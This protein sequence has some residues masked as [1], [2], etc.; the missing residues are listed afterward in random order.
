MIPGSKTTKILATIVTI[1]LLLVGGFYSIRPAKAI[2]VE[3]ILGNAWDTTQYLLSKAG[4]IAFQ[5]IGRKVLNQLAYD[6]ATSI[7]SGGKG[8]QPLFVTKDWSAYLTDMGDKAAGDFIESFANS[9]ATDYKSKGGETDAYNEYLECYD[10]CWENDDHSTIEKCI[11]SCD[12][13]FDKSI[14][15]LGDNRK[16]PML[17][18]TQSPLGKIN[19]CNP[20]TP[21]ASV[22]IGLGLTS[23]TT[24]W[25]P[26]CKFSKMAKNWTDFGKKLADMKNPDYM[27]TLITVFDDPYS[28]DLGAALI[29]NTN[30][31]AAEDKNVADTRSQLEAGKGWLDTRDF[32]GNL[33]GT[34]LNSEEEKKRT[35][36]E[37]W[38]NLD[39]VTGDI[40]VDAA[41]IFLNRLALV[42]W[43]NLMGELGS[44]QEN[45]SLGYWSGRPTGRSGLQNRINSIK[46]PFYTS[47]NMTNLLSDL[48]IC[49]ESGLQSSTSCVITNAFSD[50]VTSKMTLIEAVQSGRVPGD[51]PFGFDNKG[52][53]SLEYQQGYPYRSLLILRKYRIIPVGWELAAQKIQ[54]EYSKSPLGNDF[55]S[56]P[57]GI[58]L[59]DLIACYNSS[60][61]YTGYY[62]AWC[63][64]LVDPHWVLELPDT[65]CAAKGYGP[66]LIRE[67]ESTDSRIKYCSTDKGKTKAKIDFGPSSGKGLGVVRCDTN[68][69]CCKT[70]EKVG[71]CD[72]T[73]DYTETQTILSRSKDYC[74]DEQSCI[75]EG[76]DGKCQFYGYCAKERRKWV[77]S[78]DGSDESCNPIYNTCRAFTGG[79]TAKKKVN[80]LENTLDFSGCNINNAGCKQYAKGMAAYNVNNDV[81]TWDPADLIH[82]DSDAQECRAD[83]EGCHEFVRVMTGG[84]ANL[85]GDGGFENNDA[86]HWTSAGRLSDVEKIDGDYSLYI[87]DMTGINSKNMTLLPKGFVFER[88][89]KYAISADVYVLNGK[90]ELGFGNSADPNSWQKYYSDNNNKW[91]SFSIEFTNDFTINADTFYLRG[92]DLSSSFYVDNLKIEL[93]GISPYANYGERGLVYEK[94]LPKYLEAYCY[95]D[96]AKGDYGLK[97][98][99]ASKCFDYVRKCNQDEVGCRMFTDT[100][101]RENV[102]AV[103]NLKDYCAKECV[104]FNV[105]VQRENNYYSTRDEYFVPKTAE[106]CP[107]SANG[108][109]LF[110]N[111]DKQGQGG[112]ANEYYTHLRSCVKPDQPDA[113]CSEFYTWEGSNESGYQLV[114]FTLQ[115]N[116]GSLLGEPETT[117]NDYLECNEYVFKMAANNPYYNSDC[118]QFYTRDGQI[119]YHLYNATIACSEQCTP[120]RLAENNLDVNI[121]NPT[122]CT[123][124]NGHW[125]T[126]NSVCITCLGNGTWSDEQQGCIYQGLTD[127]SSKC[128]ASQVGCSEYV[129]NFG[130]NERVIFNS[131]F[132]KI[133]DGWNFGQLSN[134]STAVGGHS[135]HANRGMATKN[136]SKLIKK[137]KRYVLRFL[138]KTDV[139][140]TQNGG[141]PADFLVHVDLRQGTSYLQHFL[142]DNNGTPQNQATI[143]LTDKWQQYEV[144]INDIDHEIADDEDLQIYGNS[145]GR[146]YIDNIK[147]VEVSDQYFLIKNSWSWSAA[148]NEDNDGKSYPLFALG[149]K[150]Y[151]DVDNNYHYL[152]SFSQICQDSAAGCELMIDTQ[153]SN[154]YRETKSASGITVPADEMVYLVYDKDK[155]CGANQQGCAR[156]GRYSNVFNKYLDTYLLNEPD[157]YGTTLCSADAVGCEAWTD[158]QGSAVYFKDPGDR[159]C[160]YRTP[161]AGGAEAW[162]WQYVKRCGGVAIGNICLANSDCV[163]GERCVLDE[164]DVKCNEGKVNENN[165]VPNDSSIPKTLGYGAPVYQPNTVVG[166]CPAVQSSCTE[167]IDPDSRANGN[168]V[169]DPSMVSGGLQSAWIST[170]NGFEQKIKVRTNT[171][172]LVGYIVNSPLGPMTVSY[173]PG[174]AGSYGIY[175]LNSSNNLVRLE[176]VNKKPLH[177]VIVNNTSEEIYLYNRNTEEVEITIS[178]PKVEGNLFVRP[179]IVDYK[180]ANTLTTEA[181]TEANFVKGQILFNQRS[182]NGTAKKALQ[183]DT[184]LSYPP[185]TILT[186]GANSNA[187]VLLQV[188][189]DRECAEWLGCKISMPNPLKPDEDVC[190]ERGLC[191]QMDSTGS[192]INFLE[193]TPLNQTYDEASNKFDIS[194]LTG[195]TKVGYAGSKF[196]ADYLPLS[197]MRQSGDDTLSFDGNNG[198]FEINNNSGFLNNTGSVEAEVFNEPKTIQAQG[199]SSFLAPDGQS[200]AKT[201][202]CVSK[203]IEGV[204][205]GTYIFSTYVYLQSGQNAKVELGNSAV[206]ASDVPSGHP[207]CPFVFGPSQEGNTVGCDGA[208]ST[209]M[210]VADV[211]ALSQGRWIRV[212]KKIE[213]KNNYRDVNNEIRVI[214][215]A[216][217]SM[218]FDDVRLETGLEIR[219]EEK[220]ESRYL[221]SSCRLYP[222]DNALSCDYYDD[223]NLRQK[224]WTGY[225]LEWDPRDES[226]CLLWYPLDKIASE[227]FEGGL[228]LSFPNDIY[229]CIDAIDQ[230]SSSDPT[231]PE[232]YC[233]QFIKVNKSSYWRGRI[234]GDTKGFEL[235]KGIL[236]TGDFNLNFGVTDKT[237]DKAKGLSNGI[238]LD[239][240]LGLFGA[241]NDYE[242]L[243]DNK[244]YTGAEG[245]LSFLPYYGALGKPGTK[246][247]DEKNQFLPRYLNQ[248]K[249]TL[250]S[251]GNDR[252]QEVFFG[253]SKIFKND[254]WS[255]D[256]GTFDGCFV[257]IGT[258]IDKNVNSES[259]NGLNKACIWDHTMNGNRGGCKN[260]VKDF[261]NCQDGCDDELKC[262]AMQCTG[263]EDNYICNK[264]AEKVPSNHIWHAYEA[265]KN[266]TCERQTDYPNVGCVS[267]KNATGNNWTGTAY[268]LYD[269]LEDAWEVS[270]LFDCYNHIVSYNVAD[271]KVRAVNAVKRL[272]TKMSGCYTWNGKEYVRDKSDTDCEKTYRPL[273]NT[274]KFECS[275]GKRPEYNPNDNFDNCYIKPIITNFKLITNVS[276][277]VN[278]SMMLTFSFNVAI[279]KEQLPLKTY[280]LKW[281]DP[282]G[283]LP[284]IKSPRLNLGERT[285]EKDPY[286]LTVYLDRNKALDGVLGPI[287]LTPEIAVED[288]WGIIGSASTQQSI[289]VR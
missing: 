113:N 46:E 112:E 162:Y 102:S 234:S 166:L 271:S 84:G 214:F 14:A 101:T 7:G 29:L 278:D 228:G 59:G 40:V 256:L 183:Y 244:I 286:Y 187:N 105:F 152:K 197:N 85:V 65:Y 136:V 238:P 208:G 182:Q 177:N 57:N 236:T 111:L 12:E 221:A 93:G 261:V 205:D 19:I 21:L 140:A 194:N 258:Q 25:Q 289:I 107:A 202:T 284:N 216:N 137:D 48:S 108:C 35:D 192:C 63:D 51:L 78:H 274:T 131:D 53:D 64:G 206:L 114:Y 226:A 122:D 186:G 173:D 193:T 223:S 103:A 18:T 144:E 178:V 17:T 212:A 265:E 169:R 170:G 31:L 276:G 259:E 191:N 272:W 50:A 275:N 94:L 174:T 42:A 54:L 43:Q 72:A 68:Q 142:P 218:Y 273:F 47:G 233:K 41:N 219:K 81:A 90:A 119:S 249:A 247:E 153:N 55:A 283:N 123:A 66:N 67:P 270:C 267:R 26:N 70:D 22:K 9:L 87:S 263:P 156:L 164:T 227:S 264:L 56:R 145:F 3:D 213:V 185:S 34:P 28:S 204:D 61:E 207:I 253:T 288:N 220:D 4:S 116:A 79:A 132:E 5:N 282:K 251:D 88:D 250:D 129:G 175:Y 2:P 148:C 163:T 262:G 62:K 127:G 257:R 8:Q 171:L 128:S 159:V 224:G 209:W 125:D 147:L 121:T 120:Y 215:C 124:F 279:D 160:E 280:T 252:P 195:Y 231:I 44:N 232:M 11:G 198:S 76:N 15:T 118:R 133:L 245:K 126:D 285:S 150:E 149:C 82:F 95:K 281:N 154:D 32:A 20:T 268:D 217:G 58:S 199:L 181:P 75:K 73:C 74:A 260:T 210:E 106:T 92:F 86:N 80:Y 230:C 91:E 96:P 39:T 188:S 98:D 141:S 38:K 89:R 97:V 248:C 241:Y 155:S 157:A 158:D 110:V 190:Y 211:G 254:K 196:N 6:T 135:L 237:R 243:G 146:F 115:A 161:K 109:S 23:S 242:E 45:N 24:N 77:Y 229:Y 189:P 36:E 255:A 180:L 222:K 165:V 37:L 239:T 203:V 104:G 60:D 30:L 71:K 266:K 100:K 200:L 10:A 184:N 277:G 179:A 49:D 134:E 27:S 83:D 240:A 201:N 33:L 246:E 151:K 225:C 117:F 1:V 139:N 168:L 13:R 167:F 176:D 172:Y 138:A 52:N 16:S 99:A 235:N 130:N 269:L 69:D 287:Q 143:P